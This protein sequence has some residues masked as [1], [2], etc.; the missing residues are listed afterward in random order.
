MVKGFFSVP[1]PFEC[2]ITPRSEK[3]A[4]IMKEEFAIAEREGINF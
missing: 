2:E 3:H 4:K 1:I